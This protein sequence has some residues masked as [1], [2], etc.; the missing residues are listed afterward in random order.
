MNT[1]RLPSSGQARSALNGQ[2]LP[3]ALARSFRRRSGAK[4]P[5]LAG[6]EPRAHDPSAEHAKLEE[7]T[8]HFRSELARAHL[9]RAMDGRRRYRRALDAWGEG[10]PWREATPDH[11]AAF[12]GPPVP[13]AIAAL[14]ELREAS[15]QVRWHRSRAEGQRER[16]A[17]VRGCGGRKMVAA[18]RRCGEEREPVAEGCGVRRVCPR[19]DVSGAVARRARFGRARG[20]LMI[21]AHRYGLGL[22]YRRGGAYSEKMLTLTLPHF[23][24]E[25]ASGVVREESRD[26]LHARIV[27]LF[28]AWPLFLRRVNAW[29]RRRGERS[30]AYHR[31]FEWTPGKRESDRDGHPHFHVYF[32]APWM[33]IDL[34]RAWWAESLRE[35][36]WRVDTYTDEETGHERD[37]VSVHL[38]QLRSFDWRAVRELMKGGKRS[39]LTLSRVDFK[40]RDESRDWSMSFRGGAGV[41]AFSYSEGWTLGDVEGVDAATLARLYMALEGR[42]LTQANAGFFLEDEPCSCGR[43]HLASAPGLPAFFVRFAS[44]EEAAKGDAE[45]L[46]PLFP[47]LA[48]ARPGAGGIQAARV[49]PALA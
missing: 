2:E 3:P 4:L 27:A 48:F 23:G 44:A 5:A 6:E 18:C 12:E 14:D 28:K 35:V 1:T 21:D 10:E 43:C 34:L 24:L 32:W 47:P 19:C 7:L 49:A 45:R 11:D 13:R 33:P 46:R 17:R 40:R 37:R 8:Q 38:R 22:R 25:D 26:S 41:D 39:A 36:G 15:N 31:A 30:V 16:F 20:R 29:F 9:R 42:R